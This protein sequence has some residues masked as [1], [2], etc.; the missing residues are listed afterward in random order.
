MKKVSLKDIAQL[1]G[2][3]P[4][5][6]SFVLNGKAQQMRI[7]PAVAERVEQ[8][9]RQQGYTPNQVAI[10]LRTGETRILGLLVEDIS[11]HFFATLAR[12]IETEAEKFGYKIVY[13]STENKAAKGGELIRML[14]QHQVD[15]F[16]ITPSAG[17]EADIEQLIQH[18]R[19][20]VLIDR[21][22]PGLDVP[23]VMVDNERGVTDGMNFLLKKGYRK[24]GFVNID[25]DLVQIHQRTESYKN[26]LKQHQIPFKKEYLLHVHYPYTRQEG[27]DAISSFIQENKSS[28]DAVFFATNYLGIIGLESIVKAGLHMPKDIAMLCFDDHDIFRLYPEGITIIQQPIEAIAETAIQLLMNELGKSPQKNMNRQVQL[29]PALISRDSA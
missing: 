9:A 25:L 15:G 7:T 29:L 14:S 12:T 16:L 17:M 27:M 8:V 1:A 4:S 28:L 5:T 19:P 20:V 21:Y 26:I 22:F 11:N 6:V 23:Y 10:S 18:K 2:V 3:S 24:I 13:A